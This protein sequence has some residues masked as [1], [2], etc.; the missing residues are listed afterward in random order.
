M[1]QITAQD[2]ALFAKCSQF[3]R[4]DEV[5]AAGLY[6]YFKPITESED[7]TVVVIEEVDT[8]NWGIGG[9]TVSEQRKTAR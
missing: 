1:A 8:D 3:T 2:V 6:P 4:A 9:K 7:T 5:K